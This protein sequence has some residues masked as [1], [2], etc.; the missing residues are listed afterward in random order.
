MGHELGS[1]I[2]LTW[3]SIRIIKPEKGSRPTFFPIFPR[4]GLSLGFLHT[5]PIEKGEDEGI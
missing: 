2:N 3:F 1:V 5:F 4:P